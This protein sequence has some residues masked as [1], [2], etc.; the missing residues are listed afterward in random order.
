MSHQNGDPRHHPLLNGEQVEQVKDDPE[1]TSVG[2]G[3]LWYISPN[4]DACA[5]AG[6]PEPAPCHHL[7]T[8]S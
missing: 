6:N 4:M 1:F 3:Y 2:A 7:C 5:G 8:G